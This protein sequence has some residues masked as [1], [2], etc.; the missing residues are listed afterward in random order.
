LLFV[1]LAAASQFGARAIAAIGDVYDLHDDFSITNNPNTTALGGTWSFRNDDDGELLLQSEFPIGFIQDPGWDLL[2]GSGVP[3]IWKNGATG[4]ITTHPFDPQL[5]GNHGGNLLV[6]WVSPE[7]GFARVSGYYFQDDRPPAP[8]QRIMGYVLEKNGVQIDGQDVVTTSIELHF[9]EVIS[10]MPGDIIDM[11]L[12][13]NRPGAVTPYGYFGGLSQRIE[14]V[15]APLDVDGDYNNDGTVGAADYVVWRDQLGQNVTLPNDSTPG[16]VT[17]EDYTVWSANFGISSIGAGSLLIA[18]SVP[19]P[20]ALLLL[21]I[22]AVAG[23]F[24]LHTRR[25][26]RR[27]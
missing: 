17:A 15:T 16:M 1:A 24:F 5:T 10:I 25:E 22:G 11:R 18:T 13:S 4:L 19:E 12:L 27:E 8:P 3:A 21:A 23:P 6:R 14:I 9:D 2:G 26:R 20:A 7:A